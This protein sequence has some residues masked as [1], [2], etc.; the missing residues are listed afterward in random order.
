MAK[1]DKT[2]N[3]RAW[4]VGKQRRDGFHIRRVLW[5]RALARAECRP[6]EEIRRAVVIVEGSTFPPRSALLMRGLPS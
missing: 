5:G 2:A 4:V 3:Y 1:G 6:G